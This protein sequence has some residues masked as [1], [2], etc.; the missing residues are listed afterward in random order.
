MVSPLIL[1]DELEG[2][3]LGALD[4][5]IADLV[6]SDRYPEAKD[7]NPD[8]AW[9]FIKTYGTINKIDGYIVAYLVDTPW[10]SNE[11]VLIELLVLRIEPKGKFSQ[12]TEFFESE[13]KR[14]G[15]KRVSTGTLLA[16]DNESLANLYIRRGFHVNAWQLCKEV[17]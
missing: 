8:K 17:G 14:L 6:I 12:V 1:N 9:E 3:V 5:S 2:A 4:A 13:A 11:A 10:F 7:Y 16:V 15:C